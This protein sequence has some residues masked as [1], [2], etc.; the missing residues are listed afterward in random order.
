MLPQDLHTLGAH[1]QSIASTVHLMMAHLLLRRV[2]TSVSIASR[3]PATATAALAVKT[4]A[5][6]ARIRG[7]AF[8]VRLARAYRRFA[9]IHGQR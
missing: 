9:V 5:V 2:G 4:T 1:N 7:P 3:R 6:A 8:G